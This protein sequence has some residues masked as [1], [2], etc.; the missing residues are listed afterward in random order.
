MPLTATRT[1]FCGGRETVN[2]DDLLTA[3]EGDPFQD[4]HELTETQIA[5]LAAPHAF[6]ASEVEVFKAQHIVFVA[7]RVSQLKVM[8]A[9]LISQ[10]IAMFCQL[11]FRAS[12]AVRS[13][14][15]ARKLAIQLAGF[16]H[17][18]CVELR[19]DVGSTFIV[20]E[21]GFQPKIEAAALTHADSLDA[22]LL[23]DAEHQPQPTRVIALDGQGFDLPVHRGA[24]GNGGKGG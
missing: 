19:T 1:D 6:H 23:N 24:F 17:S 8:I 5:H 12:V 2:F 18:L 16:A 20:D 15:L 22:E 9:A 4:V 7:Q 14:N 13:Y 3:L 10:V 11:A 21:E